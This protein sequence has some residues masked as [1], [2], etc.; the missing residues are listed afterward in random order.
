MPLWRRTTRRPRVQATARHKMQEPEEVMV[1][2]ARTYNKEYKN[3]NEI[4]IRLDNSD[5][6][7]WFNVPRKDVLATVH[8]LLKIYEEDL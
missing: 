2:T 8:L 1:I 7:D 5:N 6:G 4:G 3:G